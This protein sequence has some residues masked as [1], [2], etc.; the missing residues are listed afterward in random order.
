MRTLGSSPTYERGD[1]GLEV[2]A[3]PA[4]APCLQERDAKGQD[5]DATKPLIAFNIIGG[6][7][8]S[9]S[10]A[11]ETER[12]GALQG[13]GLSASGNEAGT[14]VAATL[15]SGG[16]AGGFHTEPSVAGTLRSN[17]HNNSDAGTEARMHIHTAIGVRRLTPTECERLQGFPDGWTDG[18]AD[19]HRYRML[20][21]AVPV[22]VAE[23]IGRRLVSHLTEG[24]E[25]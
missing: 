19:T 25:K 10:H 20:G 21:N 15:N 1:G 13:K 16:N 17:P 24:V 3:V 9:R 8:H 12:T 18:A 6:A 4:L 2:V 22:P 5:S 23:W 11:Y 7:Q 14:V